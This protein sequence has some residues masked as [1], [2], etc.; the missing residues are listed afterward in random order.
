M[1]AD[2]R[3]HVH[4]DLVSALVE[5]DV[6]GERLTDSDII[7][8]AILMIVAGNETTTK[9]LS[10]CIYWATR[11]PDQLAL[12]QQDHARVPGW[13]NETVRYDTSTHMLARYLMS[14]V[15]LH[16]RV[17][18]AGSQ[19]LLL[20]GSANRDPDVFPDGD[21]YDIGRDTTQLISFGA[22]RH[23]CLGA[24]LARLES[25]IV[26]TELMSRVADIAVDESRDVVRVR[27]VNVRG[28]AH[29]P[30]QVTPR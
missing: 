21:R 4:D 16:G 14:D 27:S 12:I 15:E 3:R 5:T 25:N 23:Y 9:L 26:L 24:N 2:R 18:P 10:N 17:A 13:V 30:V 1:I 22:G 28:F 7:G 20:L 11:N 19:L 6:D 8:F 29:L